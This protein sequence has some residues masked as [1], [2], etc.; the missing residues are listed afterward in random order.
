MAVTFSKWGCVEGLY[1][2]SC[3]CTS[4]AWRF[5]S[6]AAVCSDTQLPVP[7]CIVWWSTYI[8]E[9]KTI[10]T[11]QSAMRNVPN[12]KE[13]D[14]TFWKLWT[15]IHYPHIVCAMSNSFR[16]WYFSHPLHLPVFFSIVLSERK[17]VGH[18]VYHS[19]Q[20]QWCHHVMCVA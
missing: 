16:T 8:E 20:L 17:R 12:T 7:M 11:A 18:H 13:T 2:S 6:V 5:Q 4:A 19:M 1:L 3:L 14:T 15:W 10:H 9:S